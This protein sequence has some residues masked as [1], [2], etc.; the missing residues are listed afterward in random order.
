MSLYPSNNLISSIATLFNGSYLAL[1]TSNPGADN[2]GT[3]VAGGSYSRKAITFGSVSGGAIRNTGAVTFTGL[4][5]GTITH[6]GIM[7]ASS[8]GNLRAYGP[9]NSQLVSISGDEVSF[10]INAIEVAVAGS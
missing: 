4:P 9:L 6:Y 5:N 10:P 2:T 8:G 7:S 3:E 1:Y